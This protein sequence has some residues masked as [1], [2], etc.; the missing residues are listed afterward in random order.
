M[1]WTDYYISASLNLQCQ[2]IQQVPGFCDTKDEII[3]KPFKTFFSSNVIIT[4]VQFKT[5]TVNL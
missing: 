4:I 5:S 2:T 3:E 1:Q